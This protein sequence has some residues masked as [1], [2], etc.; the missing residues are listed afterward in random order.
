MLLE[1]TGN[2]LLTTHTGHGPDRVRAVTTKLLWMLFIII[3]VILII[4]FNN[5]LLRKQSFTVCL[6]SL[7]LFVL[8]MALPTAMKQ[9]IIYTLNAISVCCIVNLVLQNPP[10]DRNCWLLLK[11]YK[12][13][14]IIQSEKIMVVFKMLWT[15]C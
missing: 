6:N 8:I 13:L 1:I 7:S 3:K 15:A 2:L 9:K 14:R 4:R 12:N 11:I 5:E 10:L